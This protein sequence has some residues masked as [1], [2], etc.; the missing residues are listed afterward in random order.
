ML[1]DHYYYS[2][3]AFFFARGIDP[4][5]VRQHNP[6]IPK[7]ALTVYLDV[8]GHVCHERIQS[9]DGK[10]SSVEERDLEFL[11]KVR[12]GFEGA[13]DETFL[14]IDGLQSIESIHETVVGAIAASLQGVLAATALR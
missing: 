4:E 3:Q 9:R 5:F 8:P 11:E 7:P 10:W 6:G 14:K 13:A 2:A 12:L 1:C